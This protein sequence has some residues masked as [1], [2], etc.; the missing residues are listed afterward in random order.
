LPHWGKVT[1]FSQQVNSA[2]K[3]LTLDGITSQLQELVRTIAHGIHLQP[4]QEQDQRNID[5]NCNDH[6]FAVQTIENA[7]TMTGRNRSSSNAGSRFQVKARENRTNIVRTHASI[8]GLFRQ[9]A[10]A[11]LLVFGL[12]LFT[13]VAHAFLHSCDGDSCPLAICLSQSS[14]DVPAPSVEEPVFPAWILHFHDTDG[15]RSRRWSDVHP[16]RGPPSLAP[17]VS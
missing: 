7:T 5:S 17:S 16:I 11:V 13:G 6:S 4:Q 12:F 2:S 3:I 9:I 10:P 1:G 8:T 15:P 14:P